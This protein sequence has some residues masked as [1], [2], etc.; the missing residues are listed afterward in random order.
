MDWELVADQVLLR[1][2]R[3]DSPGKDFSDLVTDGTS[4]RQH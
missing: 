4:F 2:G 3:Y 1:V